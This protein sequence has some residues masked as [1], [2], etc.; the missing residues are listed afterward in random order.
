MDSQGASAGSRVL[1]ALSSVA[2]F[3][4]LLGLTLFLTSGPE[5]SEREDGLL[6][7]IFLAVGIF[8]SFVAGRRS[9]RAAAADLLRPKGRSAVRTIRSLVAG[10]HGFSLAV[11]GERESI[12][13][14]AAESE[15]LVP[16]IHVEHALNVVQ[17]RIEGELRTAGN[18]LEDWRDVVPDE[19]ESVLRVEEANDGGR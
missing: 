4:A 7:L 13:A 17:S 11:D 19:V 6:Q 3:A 16:L 10:I 18:A 15:D 14:I 5:F 2:V 9:A 1:W 12:R 8:Y